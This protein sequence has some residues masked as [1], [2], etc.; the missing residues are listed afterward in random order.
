ML[1][2]I[3]KL[4][5]G[6]RFYRVDLH[7]HTPADP[8][9]FFDH[10]GLRTEEERMGF[11]R[12]YVRFAKEVQGLDIIGITDHNDVSW[13]RYIQEAGRDVGLTVIPGVELGAN[14][15]KRNIHYL[16]LFEPETDPDE[17]DHFISSVGLLPNGRFDSSGRPRLTR[18]NCRELTGL[19]VDSDDGLPGVAIAAHVTRKNGLLKELEG[20][21]RIL[22]YEDENLLAVE[23]PNTKSALG[24]F[25]RRVINGE[26]HH[27]GS[28]SVACLN[29]S[30]GR[31]LGQTKT[32]E[33]LSVGDRATKIKLSHFSLNALRHAFIDHDSRIRLEGEH[34]EARYPRVVG[35]VVEGGFLSAK[36]DELQMTNG[37]IVTRHSSLVTP[38]MVHLNPNLNAVIGGRGAGKSTLLEAL[39]FVFDVQA[40]TEHT[41]QQS[42]MAMA[43]TL[44]DGSRVTAWYETADGTRY[45]LVRRVGQPTEIR[46]AASGDILALK[47]SSL[48]ANSHPIDVYGQ[49]EVYEIANDADFQLN[50]IDSYISDALGDIRRR[51]N[52]LL[53]D[54]TTNAQAVQHLE[55]EIA[56]HEQSLQ[57]LE[58]VKLEIDRLEKDETL[59]QLKRKKGLEEE[60]RALQTLESRF[61]H[62]LAVLEQAAASLTRSPDDAGRFGQ[63]VDRLQAIDQ[64]IV[65][66]LKAAKAE[67]TTLWEEARK[68]RQSW[69]DEYASSEA[70]Y[71][72]LLEKH[73]NSLS[74][75]RYF[76]LQNKRASLEAEAHAQH[77]R[78]NN[79]S[80]LQAR[81]DLLLEALSNLREYEELKCRQ[82][83]VEGL[84]AAL[85]GSVRLKILPYGN[86]GAY[87]AYLGQLFKQ[88]AKG[89]SKTVI[90]A[91]AEA[92]KSPIE[93][94]RALR[95]EQTAPGQVGTD[96]DSDFGISKAYRQKLAKMADEGIFALETYRIPDMPEIELKVNNAYRSLL[97]PP[98]VPGLSTGQKCTAILSIILVERNTPLIIDQPEDDL[99]NAFIFREIVQTLRREKERRQF[100]I[101]TH[102]A[103]IPV[104]GDA[105]LILLMDA[106][107]KNGWIKCAGSIDDPAIREPV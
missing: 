5:N 23:I 69:E 4:S 56:E 90:E 52:K 78:L 68:E 103:N 74:I 76:D 70:Q 53:R 104:S 71:Q 85:R 89:I 45:E 9:F 6:A 41:A 86:R 84:N 32:D 81:R 67:V 65:E 20:E 93:L 49:K 95:K 16:A 25:N 79:L 36:S 98:G 21:S 40:K 66:A 3:L 64:H 17:I 91:L 58:A 50:L 11:A 12:E 35:L 101:A 48:L 33:R 77:Q 73:G 7:N 18:K 47:P 75:E 10:D 51:E 34:V 14:E 82:D 28:K 105:E 97:P 80:E 26:E 54:L 88:H 29:S 92:Q 94:A 24:D 13:V 1:S 15:G 19:I 31:G 96:L 22:A 72:T 61:K 63:S 30:D 37:Q 106:D 2:D 62:R 60:K 59:G 42:K 38:F 46:D 102:N 107:E 99:D 87:K 55:M 57:D 8:S 100:V 44:P 27:Y 83:K 39:R 43:A